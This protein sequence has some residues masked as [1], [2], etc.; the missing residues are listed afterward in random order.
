MEK[1]KYYG[2]CWNPIRKKIYIWILLI[3]VCK[4][5]KITNK[6]LVIFLSSMLK[7]NNNRKNISRKE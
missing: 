2:Q 1:A 4:A 6:Y 5:H 7:K 3:S